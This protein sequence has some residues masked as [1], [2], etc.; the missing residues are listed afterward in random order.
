MS[1]HRLQR[2]WSGQSEKPQIDEIPEFDA[3]NPLCP[4]VTRPNGNVNFFFFFFDLLPNSVAF[5]HEI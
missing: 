1:P 5:H 4:G 3:T 2:P